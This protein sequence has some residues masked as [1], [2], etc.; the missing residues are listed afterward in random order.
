MADEVKAELV[1]SRDAETRLHIFERGTR[2][3]LADDSIT[4][5]LVAA[6]LIITGGLAAPGFVGAG[7]TDLGV[8]WLARRL[9][10][11]EFRLL[12]WLSREDVSS[13]GECSGL[14]LTSLLDRGLA[15]FRDDPRGRGRDYGLVSLT[16]RGWSYLRARRAAS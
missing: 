10:Q 15:S 13:Y 8:A 2:V 1:L 7:L 5:S 14:T 3:V 6:G 9:S 12:E 11:E 4:G 16:D